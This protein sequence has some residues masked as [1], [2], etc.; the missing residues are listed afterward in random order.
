MG[1]IENTEEVVYNPDA[2]MLNNTVVENKPMQDDPPVEDNSNP[3]EVV[4]NPDAGAFQQVSDLKTQVDLEDYRKYLGED[5]YTHT[6]VESLNKSRAINQPWHHQAANM[7]GQVVVGELIGGTVEGLGYLL[8]MKGMYDIAHG[9]EEEWGNWLSDIGKGL[10]ETAQ[11]GM[12]I[13]QVDPGGFNPGDSGWWFSNGVSV[14]SSLSMLIPSMG[15]VKGLS[16]LGKGVSKAAGLINKSLDVASNMT[17]QARWASTGISQAIVSRHIENSMEASGTFESYKAEKLNQIDPQTGVEFTEE[18]ATQLAA[19]AAASNYRLGWAMLA[20]DIPQYLAL[21]KV[22]NPRTMKMESA[23][24]KASGAGK[25]SKMGK[26]GQVAKGAGITFVSEGLEESYQYYIAERGR[27]LSELQ[28]GL[29]D[30]EEYQQELKS[31]VG[32]E[33]MLTSAFWGGLGGNIFQA[34]GKGTSELFKSKTQRE[35]EKNYA[36]MQGDFLNKRGEAFKLMQ[37][38]LAAAD[39]SGDPARREAAIADMMLSMT[40]EAITLDKYDQH[41]ET[42]N[43]TMNMSKEERDAFAKE[44]GIELNQELFKEYVPKA[45]KKSKEI[46][47]I[48]DNHFKRNDANVTSHLTRND[49]QILQFEEAISKDTK[50]IESLKEAVPGQEKMSRQTKTIEDNKTKISALKMANA[51]HKQHASKSEKKDSFYNKNRESLIAENDKKIKELEKDIEKQTKDLENREGP[52]KAADSRYGSGYK[53]AQDAIMDKLVNSAMLSD[54]VVYRQ[55]ENV[56]LK[57]ESYQ[58]ELKSKQFGFIINKRLVDDKSAEKLREEINESDF[59]ADQKE[60]LLKQVDSKL[61]VLTDEA[62]VDKAAADKEKADE[63]LAKAQAEK[64]KENPGKIVDNGKTGNIENVLDDP[65]A[66]E[67]ADLDGQNLDTDEY[68]LSKESAN[69]V[70]LLDELSGTEGLD[71]YKT[72]SENGESKIGQEITYELEFDYTGNDPKILGA[73]AAYE[74]MGDSPVVTQELIDYLPIK[75]R[76][77]KSAHTFIPTRTANNP[78]FD[79]LV[80]ERKAILELLFAGKEAKTEITHTSGGSIVQDL[81]DRTGKVPEYSVS[82]LQ[83]IAS[84]EDVTFMVTNEEGELVD[85]NKDF[86]NDFGRYRMSVGKDTNGNPM[87]YRGGVFMVVKKADGTLFPMKLSIN[88]NTAEQAE[89]LADL[90]LA[91][92]VSDNKD[93]KSSVSYNT[94]L[95]LLPEDLRSKIKS[96]MGLEIEVL[97]E[98]AKLI[99]IINMFAYVSDATSGYTSQLYTKKG[100]LHFGVEGKTI[101]TE[102][103]NNSESRAELVDFLTNTKRRQFSLELYNRFPKYH[104]F[105]IDNKIVSTNS[106]ITEPLFQSDFSYIDGVPSGRRVQAYVKPMYKPEVKKNDAKITAADI[107]PNTPG[108][109]SVQKDPGVDETGRSSFNMEL[110]EAIKSEFP[111]KDYWS[112]DEVLVDG[113]YVVKTFKG[114]TVPRKKLAELEKF[115]AEFWKSKGFSYA[116]PFVSLK[117]QDNTPAPVQ[118]NQPT[119]QASNVKAEVKKGLRTKLVDLYETIS[120]RNRNNNEALSDMEWNQ[121]FNEAAAAGGNEL[122]AH[123]MGKSTLAGGLNDL[124]NLMDNGIDPNKGRGSLD[125]INFVAEPGTSGGATTGGAY[126][127]GPF[128]LIA[129]PG[130]VGGITDMS[131]VAG[132]LVNKSMLETSPGS[133]VYS[134]KLLEALREN[135]PNLIIEDY[136]N[137]GS[138]TKQIMEKKATTKQSSDVDL[139]TKTAPEGGN[140]VIDSVKGKKAQPGAVVAYRTKGKTEQ[141]M[142]DALADNAVGNPFGPYAAIKESDDGTA[143]TRFLNWLEGTGDTDVMQGY[144]NALLAKVPELKDK[145]IF[146]Y[147]NLGRPSHATALDYFL[148]GSTQQTSEVKTIKRNLVELETPITE[149]EPAVQELFNSPN[150]TIEL[151]ESTVANY[152]Y[153]LEAELSPSLRKSTEAMLRDVKKSFTISQPTQQTSKVK[154][155]SKNIS[156]AQVAAGNKSEGDI[157]NLTEANKDLNDLNDNL[158]E[159]LTD[160]GF[161]KNNLLVEI[162]TSK[163]AGSTDVVLG[164]KEDYLVEAFKKEGQI[165]PILLDKNFNIIEGR[166]RLFAAKKLGLPIKAYMPASQQTNAQQVNKNNDKKVVALAGPFQGNKFNADEDVPGGMFIATEGG[167]IIPNPN[168]SKEWISR[169]IN[170]PDA[171]LSRDV[172]TPE[173]SFNNNYKGIEVTK[174]AKYEIVTDSSGNRDIVVTEKGSI[175]FTVNNSITL[176]ESPNVSDT[177]VRNTE[178]NV[179][180]SQESEAD[181]RKRLLEESKKTKR[182]GRRRSVSRNEAKRTPSITITKRKSDFENLNPGNI[183]KDC[184]G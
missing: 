173:N 123:G 171:Y 2:T 170:S 84:N 108:D 167:R 75:A 128:M 27:L 139:G 111:N 149:F 43:N 146:Y 15:A 157:N 48:Y 72:W 38:E 168:V 169:S 163:V 182:T 73:I 79:E 16:M 102:N 76:V 132:L 184:K 56:E 180:P 133:G 34:A 105:I 35:N 162:P 28:A 8:D 90:I 81:G 20:Q 68:I 142:I 143:V 70:G 98:E 63:D 127:G 7:L 136:S 147:K 97:G 46:K 159:R 66:D 152:E 60:A 58:K 5:I 61:K 24:K 83:Q 118:T 23:L 95:P 14:A 183:K 19:D 134:P 64:Q 141:N 113:S 53:S 107:I 172:W 140:I 3:N 52:E 99:D 59:T 26:F 150:P 156:I 151:Y 120:K 57:K 175:K 22:F 47:E 50:D 17:K 178:E 87:P 124:L 100:V 174:P 1:E 160:Y 78:R 158:V 129:A 67:G 93:G 71:N 109:G 10:R 82:D 36:K 31:R 125:V 32:D 29:I 25:V 177:E 96:V 112:L 40:I 135:F 166:H 18:R 110:T 148:N 88:K 44:Q 9:Q 117:E 114:I 11:E 55:N 77:N 13:Y 45:V 101:N 176:N 94:P 122:M 103:K 39:E 62:A 104:D 30:E 4:F 92:M 33:E 154:V 153:D 130:H 42:L 86:V 74:A 137:A 85:T 181:A 21:G 119:K 138:L 12:P 116:S 106:T 179:V 6:G 161:G 89:V 69:S 115:K 131:Q 51:V 41:I 126:R 165:N 164:E 121:G 155:L 91:S 145:T 49:V 54:G 65:L 144:R 37:Q 80:Q